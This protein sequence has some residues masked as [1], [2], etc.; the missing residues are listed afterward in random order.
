MRAHRSD[1]GAVATRVPRAPVAR[2][3]GTCTVC[4]APVASRG[5]RGPPAGRVGTGNAWHSQDLHRPR[6]PGRR[7]GAPRAP[8]PTHRR[9]SSHVTNQVVLVVQVQLAERRLRARACQVDAEGMLA[10]AGLPRSEESA[11]GRH[12]MKGVLVARVCVRDKV[13]P[14]SASP[15]VARTCL[16]LRVSTGRTSAAVRACAPSWPA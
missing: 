3:A 14:H 15:R 9:R 13:G 2:A 1:Y 4:A 16:A 6:A 8:A 7:A 10:C 12:E 5:P 11:R